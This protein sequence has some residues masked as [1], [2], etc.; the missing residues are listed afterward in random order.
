MMNKTVHFKTN[1]LLKNL[2]GKDLI[3]DDNIA[4]VELVKNAYDAGSESVLINFEGFNTDG[5]TTNDSRIVIKDSGS[6]MDLSDIEHKW[7]NIAYSDKR[8]AGEQ[9]GSYFA[10]NKGVGRFSCD[11]LGKHLNLLTRKNG[12]S[13]YH[14]YL[15][16][17]DF[18][19]EGERDRTIQ[20]IDIKV[21]Q[22]TS[23]KAKSI[24]AVAMPSSGTVLV[25]SALR[26]E[27][28]RDS[29]LSLK[30]ALEKFLNPNDAFIR[31]QFEID[32]S[33][34]ELK[35][36]D[37]GMEYAER[38]NGIVRNQIFKNLKFNST[39][40][41]ST[42]DESGET[43]HTSLTHEGEPV[44]RLTEKNPYG[45][46]NIR[47]HIYY[48]NPYKKAYFKR[49]TGIRSVDFGSIFLFLNGFRVAPY[50]DRGDD[51]LGL[52]NRR[53]QGHARYLGSRDLI[54][55]IEV[56]GG[57]EEAFKPV[58]SRE[59]LKET[60]PFRELRQNFALDIIKRLEK[61]VVD[62]LDWDSIPTHLRDAVRAD[63]G[64]DWKKTNEQYVESWDKKKQRI[65]LSV[66]SFIG[67]TPDRIISFWFNPSLLEG[68]HEQRAEELN[69]LLSDV[70]AYNETQVEP[71]LKQGLKRVRQL[72]A[73]KEQ[74]AREAKSEAG[75]LRLAVAH[76]SNKLASL[77]K[78]A[79]VSKAQSL[80]L[81][82]I[83]SLD[84][85]NL[86]AFHHEIFQQSNILDN[87]VAKAFNALRASPADITS[88]SQNLER[89][90]L[91][92]K[93][94]MAIAQFATKA[95][96]RSSSAK[97]M[98]DVPGFIEQYITNV[99]KDFIGTGLSVRIRNGISGTFELKIRRIELS[100]LV[101][102]LLSNAGKAHA[103]HLTV[104]MKA[105][106]PN[107]ISIS[108][109]DDG[110]G[111]APSIENPDEVFE[112]GVTTTSGSGLGLYHARQIVSSVGGTISAIP[113]PKGI[114]I[115]VDLTR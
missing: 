13:L 9:E 106:A 68:I 16:W 114:E 80:F 51:W 4:V 65:A 108:F 19:I 23:Q 87:Y 5:V 30:K 43:V 96:F 6:G 55:R 34:E 100:I 61:F 60:N 3:N 57:Q 86:L 63:G 104:E 26:S 1:T 62:G 109:I 95:N 41:E 85:R 38:V 75:R 99:A 112:L 101:D 71:D 11:R 59:G 78:Q 17:T 72:V 93:K 58:S 52:D 66:M 42:I 69:D 76:Q 14:L 2:I 67:S 77:R 70:E 31:K 10:G 32:I 103:K 49:Q 39:Y 53:A 18:E 40:V 64:L 110:K 83:A 82:S 74:E 94:I 20:G 8:N 29:I 102:N 88:T 25:I 92:N 115:R 105:T 46:R 44:F 21:S 24:S 48:L 91:A 90:S 73:R 12:G 47:A 35:E 84:S 56:V 111:L 50:G 79:E 7:L 36:A 22:I 107:S 27:W 89:I 97:E 45:L 113:L 33:A 28:N 37:I 98:T 81:Q 54:G 15:D